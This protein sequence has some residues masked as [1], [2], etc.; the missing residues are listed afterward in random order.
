MSNVES[1]LPQ[2]NQLGEGPVWVTEESALYWVDIDERKILRYFPSTGAYDAFDVDTRVTA[3]AMRASRG[4]VTATDKGLAFWDTQ[5]Q[6]L[7]FFADPEA[8]LSSTRF[9]DGGELGLGA[10]I[11]ISTSK[12]HA[13][14][15]MALEELTTTKFIV[16]GD[17]QIRT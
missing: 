5:T 17:G 14:G 8:D 12:L 3:L 13:Y 6:A 2:R 15:P 7:D 4:F 11:G 9:N 1:V 10:E 16:F